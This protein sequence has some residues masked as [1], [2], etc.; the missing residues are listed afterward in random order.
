M[1]I[2]G[3]CEI[4]KDAKTGNGISLLNFLGKIVRVMEF[5]DWGGVFVIDSE[6]TSLATFDKCDVIRSFRCSVQ[7]EYILPPDLDMINQLTYMARVQSRKGGW[8]PILK[9]M[10][11]IHSLSKGT[12]TDTVLWQKQ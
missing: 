10:I 3:Y 11:I 12:F 5:D 8:A 4:K 1:E 9:Q 6:G 7:G 2:Q